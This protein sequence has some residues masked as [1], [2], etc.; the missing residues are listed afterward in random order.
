MSIKKLKEIYDVERKRRVIIYQND[1]GTFGYE[2]EYFSEDHFEMC[3]IPTGRKVVGFYDSAA[4]AETEAR[5]NV[6][7]LKEEND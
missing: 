5:A 7:W 3:W 4:T 2:Q 1:L 6:D